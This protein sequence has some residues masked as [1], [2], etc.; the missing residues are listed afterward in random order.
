MSDQTFFQIQVLELRGLLEKAGDDPILTPQLRERLGEVEKLLEKS[1]REPGSLLPNN[2]GDLARAAIFLRGG[3]VQGSLGIR[4]ALAGEAVIQYEKMFIEQALHDEREA[5]RQAGRQR[6]RRGTANPG[7][8]LTGTPRGSFGLEFV[9]QPTE[10]GTTLGVHAQSL[11][12]VAEALVRVADSTAETLEKTI[13]TIPPRMLSPLQKFLTTLANY[14]AEL[15]LAFPDRPAKS[16][17]ME[18]IKKAS[19]LLEREISQEMVEVSGKFRGLT[20][21]S[22]V[23]DLRTPTGEVI[24]GTVADEMTE[25]DLERI[26]ALTNHDCIATMQKTMFRKVT[27][28]TSPTYVLVNATPLGASSSAAN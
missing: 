25:D 21:E 17:P 5:A 10:G 1:G 3:G 12:N 6:R 28:P 9:A 11:R 27:G 19:E 7:L 15:R 18:Q 20:R 4:A 2:S 16:L 24:T 8:L 14:G 26:D 23:F 22:G 13:Q